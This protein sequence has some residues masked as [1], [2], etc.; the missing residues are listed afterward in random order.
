M[1]IKTNNL[2]HYLIVPNKFIDFENVNEKK[3]NHWGKEQ[4]CKRLI[5]NLMNRIKRR[6]SIILANIT[7]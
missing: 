5:R 2:W 3:L 4:T 1:K 6:F 7:K